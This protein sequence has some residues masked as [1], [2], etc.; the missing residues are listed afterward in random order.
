MGRT[1]A[2]RDAVPLLLGFPGEGV[3]GDFRPC[4]QTAPQLEFLDTHQDPRW[5]CRQGQE[6]V[7]PS[8]VRANCRAAAETGFPEILNFL[9]L[10]L[11][12]NRNKF[13]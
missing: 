13:E 9:S 6:G 1:R 4:L 3:P 2:G 12:L 5:G 10:V 8:S 7:F 11:K